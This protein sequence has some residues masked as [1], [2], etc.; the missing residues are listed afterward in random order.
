MRY[1]LSFLLCLSSFGAFA[2]VTYN[3]QTNTYTV[4]SPVGTGI[5]FDG[6]R[7]SPPV[8]PGA[9]IIVL[10][11]SVPYE[12]IG[13]V[14]LVGTANQPVLVTNSRNGVVKLKDDTFG[15]FGNSRHVVV[16]GDFDGTVAP[17]V[18]ATD[19]VRYGF[20]IDHSSL[21]L[22]SLRNVRNTRN[23]PNPSKS[24]TGIEVA[25]KS[26]DVSFSQFGLYNI[27]ACG[28][29]MNNETANYG[30]VVLQHIKI[31]GSL[32]EGIY[33]GN[34]HPSASA[35]L[36]SA[37][38]EDLIIYNTWNNALQA[39]KGV[40]GAPVIVRRCSFKNISINQSEYGQTGGVSFGNGVHAIVEN[41]TFENVHGNWLGVFSPSGIARNNVVVGSEGAYWN[42]KSN[43]PSQTLLVT[44][45]TMVIQPSTSSPGFTASSSSEP[46]TGL[47]S[48]VKAPGKAIYT[49]NILINTSRGGTEIYGPSLNQSNNYYHTQLNNAAH[50]FNASTS[51]IVLPHHAVGS[52][53][54]LLDLRIRLGHP[55]ATK[56]ANFAPLRW[57]L[58]GADTQPPSIPS[59]IGGT[60]GPDRV[61]VNWGPSTDNVGVTRYLIYIADLKADSVDAPTLTKDVVALIP[62]SSYPFSVRARDAAGNIGPPI[63]HSFQT[64]AGLPTAPALA[65]GTIT[66]T[67]VQ[68]HVAT[69]STSNGNALHSYIFYK[70]NVEIGRIEASQTSYQATGLLANTSH[71]FTVKAMDIQGNLSPSSPTLAVRTAIN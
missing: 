69:P 63:H 57:P 24:R 35:R 7:Q 19:T 23:A 22:P 58:L 52:P 64:S 10:P 28:F 15:I 44:N 27:T 25:D 12:W 49:N 46:A 6:S 13:F 33:M 53:A 32:L 56:G 29:R 3:S 60:P 1:L 11:R 45:N 17:V 41:N 40:K 71:S 34:T 38:F 8:R 51:K 39:V 14:N 20:I 31:A 66:P 37:R 54:Y 67:S 61:N 21:Y 55:N 47:Y 9:K 70:N 43:F 2:Q 48:D 50:G 65:L 42:N 36:D 68:L 16:R 26:G 4:T 59:R 62:N 18:S 30:R 5:T